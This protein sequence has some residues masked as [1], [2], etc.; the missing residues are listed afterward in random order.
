MGQSQF[1]EEKALE[2]DVKKHS[3]PEHITGGK[4]L[5]LCFLQ[6]RESLELVL[7]LLSFL[8]KEQKCIVGL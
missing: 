8:L 2:E 6:L 1:T 5:S 7:A 3:T 4:W